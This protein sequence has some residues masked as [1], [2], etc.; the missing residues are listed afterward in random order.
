LHGQNHTGVPDVLYV[1][2]CVSVC[3]YYFGQEFML[4]KAKAKAKAKAHARG[5]VTA[6]KHL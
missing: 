1:C 2:V 5:G 6:D 4:H 3:A